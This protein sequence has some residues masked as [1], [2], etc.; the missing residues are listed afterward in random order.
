MPDTY[1]GEQALEKIRTVAMHRVIA[2]IPCILA[3]ILAVVVII[4]TLAKVF[5]KTNREF[6]KRNGY[7]NH[8]LFTSDHRAAL[9]LSIIVLVLCLWNAYAG[10]K[11]FAEFSTSRSEASFFSKI[12]LVQAIDEDLKDG[13]TNTVECI[14]AMTDYGAFRKYRAE[15]TPADKRID[16]IY[17]YY[18]VVRTADGESKRFMLSESD[19]NFFQKNVH[20]K[21]NIEYYKN[22]QIVKSFRFE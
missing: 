19:Y 10:S 20:K 8:S 2:F 1:I 7:E 21:L 3:V 18:L 6:V 11:Y 15:N 12:R 17:Y 22:S 13:E 16:Y 4:L 9:I 5:G 14:S